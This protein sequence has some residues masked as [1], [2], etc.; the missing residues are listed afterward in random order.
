[1]ASSETCFGKAA[2]QSLLY[3][4]QLTLAP[5]TPGIK[6]VVMTNVLF[7]GTVIVSGSAPIATCRSGI[8][9]QLL[10]LLVHAR[11]CRCNTIL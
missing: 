5:Y 9:S 6:A 10:G 1:M 7:A 8:K 3:Y 2:I 4:Y 11:A